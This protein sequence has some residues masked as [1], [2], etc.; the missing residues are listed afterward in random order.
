MRKLVIHLF[1]DSPLITVKLNH[2]M[3]WFGL[4]SGDLEI[5][6]YNKTV[7]CSYVVD[8]STYHAGNFLSS[9]TTTNFFSNLYIGIYAS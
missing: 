3:V 5:H 8:T 9:Q 1:K 4:V 6:I 2:E 7:N